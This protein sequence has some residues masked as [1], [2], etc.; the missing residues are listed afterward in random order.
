MPELV[1]EVGRR[2]AALP[3]PR[4]GQVR[5]VPDERTVRYYGTLGLLDRPLAMRGRTA[6][7]GRKH[8]AQVIAIKR[9]QTL[10]RSLAEI[11]A[12]WPTMDDDTLGRMTGVALAKG[13]PSK[14]TRKDFWKSAPPV[15]T[16]PPPAP[17]PVARATDAAEIQIPLADN[18][19]VTIALPDDAALTSADLRAIRAAAAPLMDELARRQLSQRTMDK[20]DV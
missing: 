20:E 12:V 14:S 18:V 5:A 13:A 9:M 8:L 4:N 16:A 2:I 1:A 7:Y 11:Q 6:I 15:V 3:A 17:E 19:I 10:G